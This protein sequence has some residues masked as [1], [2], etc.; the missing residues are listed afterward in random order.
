MA[1]C[2]LTHLKRKLTK[3]PPLPSTR[4]VIAAMRTRS[5]G[6]AAPGVR[7]R[8][9][10]CRGPGCNPWSGNW[11]LASGTRP[12]PS[13]FKKGKQ[14]FTSFFQ[15]QRM[16]KEGIR[17]TKMQKP[18]QVPA[19]ESSCVLAQHLRVLVNKEGKLPA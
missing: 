5:R 8:H 7:T 16:I 19:K 1:E 10:H 9:C 6:T 12:K 13:L 4:R 15:F 17:K 2:N 3:G 11:Y 18:G 14:S